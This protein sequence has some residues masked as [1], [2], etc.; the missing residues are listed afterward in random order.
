MVQRRAA[1][2]AVASGHELT[3]EAACEILEAGGN[4]F[5]AAVAGLSSALQYR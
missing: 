3:T 5:D 1:G 4:A 2:G